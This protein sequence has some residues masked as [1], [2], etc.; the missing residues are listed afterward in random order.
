VLVQL[1]SLTDGEG[2]LW[3]FLLHRVSFFIVLV[4]SELLG[5]LLSH[6]GA[7][8][9]G[10]SRFEVLRRRL[11]LDGRRGVLGQVACFVLVHCGQLDWFVF[12]VA[13]LV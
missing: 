8:E 10:V 4:L 7:F 13:L 11:L 9:Q 6:E 3:R 12:G 1:Q 2:E 5:L